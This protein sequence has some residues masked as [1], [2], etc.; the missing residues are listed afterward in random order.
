METN[1]AKPDG[2]EP[3][4]LSIADIGRL[5]SEAAAGQRHAETLCLASIAA[6]I[7]VLGILVTGYFVANR[8]SGGASFGG[9]I[10]AYIGALMTLGS[11][12]F[13][14]AVAL[15]ARAQRFI[16]AREHMFPVDLRAAA[17]LYDPDLS[18]NRKRTPPETFELFGLGMFFGLALMAPAVWKGLRA[19][20]TLTTRALG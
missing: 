18:F 3:G 20:Y 5:Y 19:A 14:V 7:T 2:S 6:A 12:L 16:R 1:Q 13:G 9:F 4:R 15:W 8:D 17:S 10:E 11:Y